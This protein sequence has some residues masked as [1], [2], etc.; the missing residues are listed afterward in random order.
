V[1]DGARRHRSRLSAGQ[2]WGM[3]RG[4][5][6]DRNCASEWRKAGAEEANGFGRVPGAVAG[7]CVMVSACEGVR[8]ACGVREALGP[9]WQR[10]KEADGAGQL[11]MLDWAGDITVLSR[12]REK[13]PTILFPISNPFSNLKNISRRK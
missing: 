4:R 10:H 7:R 12:H 9:A 3:A 11:H 2:R 6:V 8:L 5:L 13:R 1:G